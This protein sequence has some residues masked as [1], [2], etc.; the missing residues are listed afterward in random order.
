MESGEPPHI[1]FAG[2]FGSL[3]PQQL[4]AFD[5]AGDGG[6]IRA[7]KRAASTTIRAG[8]GLHGEGVAVGL[9]RDRAYLAPFTRECGEAEEFGKRALNFGHDGQVVNGTNVAREGVGLATPSG[10]CHA[11]ILANGPKQAASLSI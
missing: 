1:V 7:G 2:G 11:T 5:G 8:P 4:P 9:G 6:K 10:P 3:G